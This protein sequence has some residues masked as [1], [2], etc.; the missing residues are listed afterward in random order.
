MSG[1]AKA[2]S[3]THDHVCVCAT[4]MEIMAK[5]QA[6]FQEWLIGRRA[7][8]VTAPLVNPWNQNAMNHN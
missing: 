5:G 8:H 3:I 2:S 7:Y 1:N 4:C 6:T